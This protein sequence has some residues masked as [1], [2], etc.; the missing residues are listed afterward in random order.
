MA[1]H[2]LIDA[3]VAELTSRLPA[4]AVA[5]LADGL[6]ETWHHHLGQGLP[7]TEAAR[8]A[9]AEFGTPTEINDAFTAQAPGR[10]TAR[11][12]LATG[13]IFGACWGSSLIASRAWTWPVPASAAA[14]FAAALVTVVTCLVAAATSRH[15]YRRTRLGNLGAAGLVALDLTMLAAVLLAAPAPAWPMALAI[16]A[17]L[18]RI[19][20]NLQ[21]IPRALR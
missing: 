12:L 17:S 19:G 1:S 11:I 7:P 6:L 14:V 8:A 13:P 2:Q 21:R 18:A 16:P 3:Y 20:V 15:S 10:R 4:N 5:E 9:I